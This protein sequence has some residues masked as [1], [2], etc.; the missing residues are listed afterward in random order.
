MLIVS[1]ILL[2]FSIDATWSGREERQRER[3]L[4]SAL[5]SDF[6]RNQALLQTSRSLHEAHRSAARD[7][8]RLSTPGSVPPELEIPDA[9]LLGL[10]SWHTYDP[11]LGSLNSAVASGQL[12]LI[13]DG[14][15]RVA[16]A[17]WVDSVEDLIEL[18][19]V[20][21]GHAQSFA[22]VAFGFV[23]FRSAVFRLGAR[24][25]VERSSTAEADY[26][27][28]LSSLRAE[29]IAAN[30]VAEIDFILDD[31]ARVESELEG[32]LGLLPETSR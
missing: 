22:E 32:I 24:E 4:L 14:Q 27:G 3:E 30:R 29:N 12:S 11:V 5:R 31:I 17:G 10:V 20:D 8:L 1:S 21:R 7:F 19:V 13:R 6:E 9:T 28:L 26:R 18:E 23:P 16:L 2:A 25:A 15:L